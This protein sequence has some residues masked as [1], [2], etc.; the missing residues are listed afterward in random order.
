M[1]LGG[2]NFRIFTKMNIKKIFYPLIAAFLAYRTI[3]LVRFFDKLSPTTT[4]FWLIFVLVLML[5]LFITGI[6]A[7][8]GFAYPTNMVLP[9]SYYVIKNPSFLRRL[10]QVLGV[11]Y[12]RK[13]LLVTFW[14]KEKNRK[15]YFNG[16]KSGL[17]NF[18]YQTRQSEFGH[19]AAFVA[20]IIIALLLLS[21]GHITAF[22][23]TMAINIPAN[24][25]P[26]VLQRIHRIQLGKLTEKIVKS[27]VANL[28]QNVK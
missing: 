10:Y 1:L 6:F 16:T 28:N 4:Q 22:L 2:S 25:Y 14:G 7:F 5:N 8:I 27:E 17:I 11:D 15:K 12:F 9:K 19:L 26:I 20:I 23:L 18:G 13:M 21:Y 24:F 3:E